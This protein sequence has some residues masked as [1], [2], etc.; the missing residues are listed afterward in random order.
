MNVDMQHFRKG[1]RIMRKY[2]GNGKKTLQEAVCNRCG[3]ALRVENGIITEGI[4]HVE[5]LWGYFSEK[6]GQRHTFDLCEACYDAV[7][8]EFAVPIENIEE[9]EL[10]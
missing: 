8:G 5:Q 7:V 4:C 6:D 10:I 2:R 9:K 1:L 3:K